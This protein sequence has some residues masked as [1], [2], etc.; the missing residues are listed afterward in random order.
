MTTPKRVAV[1]IN[2]RAYLVPPGVDPAAMVPA[3]YMLRA[4]A[5]PGQAST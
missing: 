5:P 3:G 2:G 1:L 4:Q